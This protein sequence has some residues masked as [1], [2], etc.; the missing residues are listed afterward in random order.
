MI[1]KIV[2]VG[3]EFS[4]D[5]IFRNS[6]QGNARY[7]AQNFRMKFLK[8]L[9]GVKEWN[10]DYKIILDFSNVKRISPGFANEAFA[11]F[12]KYA[13]GPEEI[14]EKIVIKNASEVQWGIILRE[15][16]SGFGTY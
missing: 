4:E 1:E 12:A 14:L 15:I 2:D 7:N 16:K 8:E 3:K 6:L 11:D 10:K 5:L 9:D 13:Q